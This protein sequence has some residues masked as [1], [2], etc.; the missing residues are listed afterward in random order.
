MVLADDEVKAYAT[1]KESWRKI[2]SDISNHMPDW[3]MRGAKPLLVS[4]ES[5]L[6][7]AEQMGWVIVGGKN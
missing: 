2:E 1:D 6:D 5:F 3:N 4:S 7:T